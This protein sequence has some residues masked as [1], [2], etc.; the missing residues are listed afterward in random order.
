LISKEINAIIK[1]I[2][3]ESFFVPPDK[4]M[5]AT[6]PKGGRMKVLCWGLLF[7][8]T[9]CFEAYAETLEERI[10]KLEDTIQKQQEM[11][12]LSKKI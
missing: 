3:V 9:T 12:S 11:L 4:K 7:I 2:F 1:S 8:L 10:K 6:D 5:S